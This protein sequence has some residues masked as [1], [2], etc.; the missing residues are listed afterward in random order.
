MMDKY[1]RVARVYTAV[2][3]MLPTCILLAMCMWKWFPQYEALVG[4][5]QWVLCLIGGTTLVSMTVGYLVSEVFKETSKWLF[6]YRMFKKDETEMP[7][8][9]MLLWQNELISPE[10]HNEI[11]AKVKETFGRKLPTRKEE[12]ADPGLSKMRIAEIV[13][14]IRQNCRGDVILRQYNIEFGFC[15]NYLGAS[16]WSILLIISIGIANLF[17]GWLSWWFIGVVLI[18]QVLLMVAC[19]LLLETRGWTYARYLFATFTGK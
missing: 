11:A 5:V 10:Y 3:G 16:V 1:I 19:Y 4:N 8:T 12:E 15:R 2:L 9:Q 13:S 6:Q 17:C 18:I 14:Q 7:T